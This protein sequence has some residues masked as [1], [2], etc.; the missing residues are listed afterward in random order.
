MRN[1]PPIVYASVVGLLL[2]CSDSTG[3]SGASLVSPPQIPE[4][5]AGA[6]QVS[7][8]TATLQ[9]G[10]TFRFT[11]TYSGNPALLGTP[12]DVAWH[13]S[14]DN[15]ATV[16]GGIVRAVSAGQAEIVAVWGG[17][18]AS[19]IVRVAGPAKSLEHA[20]AVACLMRTSRAGQRLFTQC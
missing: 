1:L 19:A 5:P 17:T 13:S 6:F 4:Y 2:A 16:T 7:P 3:P 11:T 20:D 14:D 12:G 10:Q 18:Q 15:V 9:P 8:A